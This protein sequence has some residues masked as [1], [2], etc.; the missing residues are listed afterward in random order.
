MLSKPWLMVSGGRNAEAQVLHQF[1][2]GREA[3]GHAA[4][5]TTR[6]LYEEVDR[7]L[8]LQHLLTSEGDRLRPALRVQ[9]VAEKP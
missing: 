2:S 9:F 7:R 8:D 1:A 4:H 5:R 6:L 3:G